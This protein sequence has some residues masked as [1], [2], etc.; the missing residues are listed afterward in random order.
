MIIGFIDEAVSGGARL[1]SACKTVGIASTTL[2]RW[3]AE[4]EGEDA[5][6]GPITKPPNALTAA[7]EREAI[8]IMNAR[9]HSSMSPDTL[10]P[11]LATLGI[12]VASQATLY[13]ILRRT[14]L[15]AKRGRARARTRRRPREHVATRRNQ[16]WAWDIT[17]SCRP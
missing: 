2:A 17:F 16:V 4:P 7:E 13:R 1:K 11:Y 3:R 14:K 12:Y 15:L 10:V 6:R 5:R 8:A 9:E